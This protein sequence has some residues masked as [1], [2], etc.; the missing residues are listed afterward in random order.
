MGCDSADARA[1]ASAHDPLVFGL[2][3]QA[4]RLLTG[5]RAPAVERVAH[6]AQDLP[7]GSERIAVQPIDPVKDP[8]FAEPYSSG[9]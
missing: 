3:V 5:H 7:L 2:A 9:E 4:E 1:V 8:I 6:D